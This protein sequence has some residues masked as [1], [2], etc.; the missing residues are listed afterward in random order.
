MQLP[1]QLSLLWQ[2]LLPGLLCPEAESGLNHL[3]EIV[4][5]ASPLSPPRFVDVCSCNVEI[6]V[7]SALCMYR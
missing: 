5:V 4:L 7:Q 6:I 1:F 2:F 3:S